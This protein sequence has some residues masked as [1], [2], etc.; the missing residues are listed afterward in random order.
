MNP[1]S[2]ISHRRDNTHDKDRLDP[3]K[4]TLGRG[5]GN[6]TGRL[7]WLSPNYLS[8]EAVIITINLFLSPIGKILEVKI[9]AYKTH[10]NG[11]VSL[12]SS[13]G[14]LSRNRIELIKALNQNTTTLMRL[15]LYCR[16][17]CWYCH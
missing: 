8:T 3:E 2:N 16:K 13:V 9:Q 4:R 12:S 1:R 14:K 7:P 6:F 17:F 15:L 11:Y 5:S 10:W